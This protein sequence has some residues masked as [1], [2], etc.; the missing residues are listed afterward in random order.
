M[1]DLSRYD[2]EDTGYAYDADCRASIMLGIT[3]SSIEA[4]NFEVQ[5]HRDDG[6]IYRMWH[7]H[8][9]CERVE[10]IDVCG[11]WDDLIGTPLLLAEEAS[12]ANIEAPAMLAMLGED[13]LKSVFVDMLKNGDRYMVDDI[14]ESQTWTF[15]RF[16]TIKGSVTLRWHGVSNGYYSESVSLARFEK[17]NEDE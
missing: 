6:S 15:Y 14:N 9:C 17:V 13:E 5:F 8:D 3:L 7:E 1:I 12:N 16:G 2:L 11:E 4:N 10:L